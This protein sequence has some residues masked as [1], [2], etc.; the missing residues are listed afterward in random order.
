MKKRAYSDPGERYDKALD[1]EISKS[2]CQKEVERPLDFDK[3]SLPPC[4]SQNICCKPCILSKKPFP[5]F[6]FLG[7]KAPKQ[8]EEIPDGWKWE[9]WGQG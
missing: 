9:E 8:P 2:P 4:T 6:K 5:K 3:S 7:S 1:P